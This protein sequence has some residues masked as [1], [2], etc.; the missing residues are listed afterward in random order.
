MYAPFDTRKFYVPTYRNSKT[1]GSPP[2]CQSPGVTRSTYCFTENHAN[3]NYSNT[4][5]GQS[6][7]N[8]ERRSLIFLSAGDRQEDF[9]HQHQY[10]TKKYHETCP[11]IYIVLE[12]HSLVWR[13]TAPQTIHKAHLCRASEH[14]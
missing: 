11:Y 2:G 8:P 7:N 5:E 9:R 14:L 6:I 4:T 12:H 1:T 13:I 3:S 10:R